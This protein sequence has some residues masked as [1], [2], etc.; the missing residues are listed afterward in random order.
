MIVFRGCV[1]CQGDL[2]VE[3]GLGDADLVCLQCGYRRSATAGELAQAERQ[4]AER[5]LE[6][7]GR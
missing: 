6:P 3:Q 5:E 7:A 1:K 4:A 2:Y